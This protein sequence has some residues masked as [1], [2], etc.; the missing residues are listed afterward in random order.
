MVSEKLKLVEISFVI[1]LI[2]AGKHEVKWHIL[3]FDVNYKIL[4]IATKLVGFDQMLKV[5]NHVNF[6]SYTLIKMS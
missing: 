1:E 2:Q 3:A 4:P 6:M 5:S